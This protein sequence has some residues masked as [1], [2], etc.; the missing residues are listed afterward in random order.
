MII[1]PYYNFRYL[2]ALKSFVYDLNIG[3]MYCKGLGSPILEYSF[4]LRFTEVKHLILWFVGLSLVGGAPFFIF[5]L[6]KKKEG[7]YGFLIG[8]QSNKCWAVTRKGGI[9]FNTLYSLSS[10]EINIGPESEPIEASGLFWSRSLIHVNFG[11]SDGYTSH[12][13]TPTPKWGMKV[14]CD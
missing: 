4:V 2:L 9:T 11:R 1:W 8:I 6:G 12:I 14:S 3:M 13:E 10:Y 7:S 5:P